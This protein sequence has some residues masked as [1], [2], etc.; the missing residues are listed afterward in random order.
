M[1]SLT[2]AKHLS[3]SLLFFTVTGL[4][5]ST[6]VQAYIQQDI[7]LGSHDKHDNINIT[8]IG[9]QH[10]QKI[11]QKGL[12]AFTVLFT[13]SIHHH[14]QTLHIRQNRGMCTCTCHDMIKIT[15]EM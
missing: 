8:H 10:Q 2:T 13:S 5:T 4:L 1:Y 9:M 15:W 7:E 12:K 14:T 11:I 6:G 3:S